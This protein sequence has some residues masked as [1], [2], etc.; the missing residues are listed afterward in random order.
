MKRRKKFINKRLNWRDPNMP[1][2]RIARPENGVGDWDVYP[3][4]S[5][6]IHRYHQYAMTIPRMEPEWRNDPSYFWA[7]DKKKVK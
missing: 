6:M 2:L 3:F 1:V 5:D 7:R 4:P